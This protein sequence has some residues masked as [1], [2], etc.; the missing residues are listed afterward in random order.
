MKITKRVLDA[1]NAQI[2]REY[3]AAYYY[4]SMSFHCLAEGLP[5][6]AEWMKT[7]EREEREHAERLTHHI[8]QRT[9]RVEL[10]S[11]DAP[12]PQHENFL[13]MF[14]SIRELET[15]ITASV[16]NLMMLACEQRDF[17][18]QSLMRWFIDEQLEEE[19]ELEN[20]I[21]QIHFVKG[22]PSAIYLMDR[23]LAAKAKNT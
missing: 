5:G 19:S 2:N 21:S 6:F 9:E 13:D 14:E 20:I 4:L 23:E 17:P 8:L 11:I 22:N 1:L 18:V 15:S 7:H 3:Y 16:H 10:A 12:P